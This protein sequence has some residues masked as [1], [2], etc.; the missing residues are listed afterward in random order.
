[1]FT[2]CQPRHQT[3]FIASFMSGHKTDARPPSSKRTNH[4]Y[5]A[6]NRSHNNFGK[7]LISFKPRFLVFYCIY[8]WL[9]TEKKQ[10]QGKK[11]VLRQRTAVKLPSINL[12]AWYRYNM[13]Y[14]SN[15]NY[16][17]QILLL[18][19]NN[20]VENFFPQ[21]EHCLHWALSKEKR[22]D[23]VAKRGHSNFVV[24][25]KR[26]MFCK[27]WLSTWFVIIYQW[28]RM[29]SFRSGLHLYLL[30][31]SLPWRRDRPF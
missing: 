12:C 23:L 29:P 28:Q 1:L 5:C 27:T 16:W 9:P 3:E 26:K 10:N 4:R 18:K 7:N 8:I 13:N 31:I 17:R 21:L 6:L 19:A 15:C 2:C 11:K 14:L 22:L 20:Q 25:T 24:L 30:N